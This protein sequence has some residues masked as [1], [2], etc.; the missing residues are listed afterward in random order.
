LKKIAEKK[1]VA[2]VKGG[3]ILVLFQSGSWFQNNRN[4]LRK[5]GNFSLMNV[6]F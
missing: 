2:E 5:T 1:K 4:L 3:G 6:Q